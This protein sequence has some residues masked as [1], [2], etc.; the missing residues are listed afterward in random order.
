MVPGSEKC[1]AKGVNY[2][3]LGGGRGAGY[4][5]QEPEMGYRNLLVTYRQ[6]EQ[7]ATTGF[8]VDSETQL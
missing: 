2:L 3:F 5:K 6:N 1:S 4:K 8:T 7:T